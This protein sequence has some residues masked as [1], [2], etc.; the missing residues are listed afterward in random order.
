MVYKGHCTNLGHVPKQE[1]ER[2]SLPAR[3]W[4]RSWPG[5][6]RHR[7]PPPQTSCPMIWRR[8]RDSSTNTLPWRRRSAGRFPKDD[9]RVLSW[10][11]N[12]PVLAFLPSRAL[13]T[14]AINT[15]TVVQV[16]RG[17]RA[18]AGHEWAAWVWGGSPPAGRPAAVAPEVGRGLEQAAGDVGEQEGGSGPGSHFPP[19]P[20][21]CQ[22][23]WIVP[24]QP[25]KTNRDPASVSVS[26]LWSSTHSTDSSHENVLSFNLKCQKLLK[27]FVCVQYICTFVCVRSHLTLWFVCFLVKECSTAFPSSI[28]QV[29]TL[30]LCLPIVL[31]FI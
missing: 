24:Q 8:P 30:W 1:T 4:T 5:W 13:K 12:A 7:R 17:L 16:W 20:E 3:T 18:A 29:I 26:L 21:R 25:S 14:S 28:S 22:T 2:D 9:F 15:V 27:L 19:V 6:S 31:S 11:H 10:F 23:G